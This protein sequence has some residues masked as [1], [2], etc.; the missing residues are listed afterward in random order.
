M[1]SYTY[2]GVVVFVFFCGGPVLCAAPTTDG[3]KTDSGII[4]NEPPTVAGYSSP[5][6]VS[7]PTPNLPPT[8]TASGTSL[9]CPG[10]AANIFSDVTITDPDDSS[11]E[12]ITVQITS[13]YVSGQDLLTLTGSHPTIA[14]SWDA[15]SG[16]LKLRSPDGKAVLYTD[17]ISALKALQFSNSSELPGNARTFTIRI[18]SAD[19]LVSSGHYYEF[20]PS[21]GISWTAA[22]TAAENRFYFGLQG[23]LCTLT[24]M[25][26]A[27]FAASLGFGA[28]WIGGSDAETE[29]V[30]QWV[31]GPE[32]GTVFWNGDIDGSSPNFVFWNKGE[33]NGKKLEDYAHITEASAGN[34]GLWND[35]NNTCCPTGYYQSK[36]YMVEY[37]GMPEDSNG[38]FVGSTSLSLRIGSVAVISGLTPSS[39]CGNG[40]VCLEAAA[41]SGT[42]QWYADANG[43][44]P[45][46]TGNSFTT[47]VLDSTTTYYVQA[48]CVYTRTPITATVN[49]IPEITFTNMPI[50]RCGAGPVELIATALYGTVNWYADSSGGVPIGT[51]SS[52]SPYVTSTT[53]YYVEAVGLICNSS[54]KPLTAS[55]NPGPEISSTNS[56][57][58]RCGA[59]AV[60][61]E[62][63][64]T[65]GT[66]HWYA[67]ADGGTVEAS[68]PS[69]TLDNVTANATYY[70]EATNNGCS[71]GIRVAVA[72]VIYPDPVIPDEALVVCPTVPLILDAGLAGLA[73]L[74]S[75]GET[76][77]KIKIS[78]PGTYTVSLSSPAP[79]SCS[80]T[81]T[82]RITAAPIPEIS[83]IA[84]DESTVIIQ[85]RNSDPSFEY[86]LD[87]ISYQ[88]SNAFYDVPGGLQTAYVRG[89]N[90]CG[91]TSRNFVVLA[92]PPFFTPNN[93]SYNDFWEVRGLV[94]YPDAELTVFDRYGK[95]ITQ[96][97]ASRLSW[98]GTFQSVP[99]PASDY[100]YV[101]NID[102][103]K[104]EIRGHFSLK[105]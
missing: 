103:T 50:S 49:S 32:K 65:V 105:R 75:T 26:E 37:G 19:Y 102:K 8:I 25:E 33:P 34:I 45:L 10:T 17:F 100:W 63:R 61:L 98:D 20:V 92:I 43:G 3:T 39:R 72:V 73:Y 76:T 18:G 85:L 101:L 78:S 44:T 13:G 70:A 104:P 46:A 22:K 93:D 12:M 27:Q 84:V 55:V 77:Q 94:D 7:A 5:A 62:A 82:I 74:W 41:S 80:Y 51:G 6:R 86:S 36:G 42:V 35:L 88:N 68:G 56:P 14:C 87:G 31:T 95:L 67:S 4:H 83:N 11:T 9:Y 38:T 57:A 59:G 79:E 29:G 58:W 52:Y 96:L 24:T 99:L 64:T 69:M 91:S 89:L 21:E 53:T 30:W 90:S 47:P 40:S 71:N 54:R 66:V 28:R 60:T 1:K 2:L 48:D 81:K 16:T 15:A 23:Y 97:N